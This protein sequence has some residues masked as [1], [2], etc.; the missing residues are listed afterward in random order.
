[1]WAEKCAR[2]E[3]ELEAQRQALEERRA[4]MER[5]RKEAQEQEV[6]FD[7]G[8]LKVRQN[9]FVWLNRR[10]ETRTWGL[11]TLETWSPQKFFDV[12][13]KPSI[14][15]AE[16]LRKELEEEERARKKEEEEKKR[17]SL[18]FSVSNRIF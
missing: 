16:Q 13:L 7:L 11:Q 5:L 10:L 14:I 3:A 17:V 12:C 15:K 6:C 8:I 2:L 4:E 9:S 1:M 18:F